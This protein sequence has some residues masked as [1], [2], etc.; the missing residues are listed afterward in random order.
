MRKQSRDSKDRFLPLD[1]PKVF[2]EQYIKDA[3][4]AGFNESKTFL[5]LQKKLELYLN[6]LR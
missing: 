1:K 3:F 4:I 2:T 5:S 6:S